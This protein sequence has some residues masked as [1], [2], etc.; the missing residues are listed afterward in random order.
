MDKF[1]ALESLATR[2]RLETTEQVGDILIGYRTLTHDEEVA[3]ISSAM[4]QPYS[5]KIE[6][7]SRSITSF[8][9]QKISDDPKE[10]DE[11]RKK[12]GSIPYQYINDFYTPFA[13]LIAK[14][15]KLTPENIE[16][17]LEKAQQP[18]AFTKLS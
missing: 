2:G 13:L 7:L 10:R 1:A 5:I 4:G 9:G 3:S 16:L 18:E 11:L 17:P 15:P 6:Q 8:D 14:I 12:L